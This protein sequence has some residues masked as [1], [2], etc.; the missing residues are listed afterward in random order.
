MPNSHTALI[1]SRVAISIGNLRRLTRRLSSLVTESARQHSVTTT[2]PE[3]MSG[4]GTL[5]LFPVTGVRAQGGENS[6]LGVA[7]ANA[8]NRLGL[9]ISQSS[10]P[11]I[12]DQ[13]PFVLRGVPA[14]WSLAALDSGQP[15]V[16]AARL[17]REWMSRT[18]HTPKDDLNRS[19]EYGAAVTMAQFNLLVGLQ[20][21]E[22]DDRPHWYSGDFFGDTFGGIRPR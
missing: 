22:G 7:A 19:L 13:G 9:E 1:S 18:Y 15:G 2:T 14:L 5:M 4:A 17:H 16:D 6:T 3:S 11:T 12:S 20:V 21:A 10:V 8:A